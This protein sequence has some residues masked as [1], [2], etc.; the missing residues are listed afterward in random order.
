[1]KICVLLNTYNSEEYVWYVLKSIYD[2]VERI[3]VI[4]GAFKKTMPSKYS[5][6]RTKQII[7]GFDDPKL[8]IIF[9][10]AHSESQLIQRG[11]VF[12]YTQG[13]D[14]L[15]LVDDDE[16]YKSRDLKQLRK[17]LK[18]T[19]EYCF[20]IRGFN[21]VNSFEWMYITDNMRVWKI[22]SDMKFIGPNNIEK[23]G[24]KSLFDREKA[25]VIPKIVRYHYSYVRDLS[26]LSIKRKQVFNYQKNK[27]FPWYQE[28][29]FVGRKEWNQKKFTGSHPAIMKNHPYKEKIWNG[30]SST[31]NG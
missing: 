5:T 23:Q 6:D 7:L 29:K 21:F 12:Q 24:Y 8:K 1:M 18:K 17:F 4:D 31:P 20:K 14:W 16:V 15:F 19:K 27:K 2:F 30:K 3:V 26:R 25:K 22:T 10:S 11:L 13:M 9:L 28:G